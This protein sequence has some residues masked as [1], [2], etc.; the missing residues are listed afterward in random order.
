[1]PPN[2]DLVASRRVIEPDQFCR[3]NS[4]G[5]CSM[6]A[7]TISLLGL[8]WRRTM[9]KSVVLGVVFLSGSFT[10]VAQAGPALE[11]ASQP[12]TMAPAVA[13]NYGRLP[14][15]FEANQGQSD[16][17]VRFTSRGNGYSLFLTDS[18]AVLALSRKEGGKGGE[19]KAT[20]PKPGPG[21]TPAK[22]LL[23]TDVVR[24]QLAGANPGLRVAGEEPL[25]GTANYFIGNDPA[26]WHTSVPTY[27]KVKY[28]EVYPGVDLVYYG[29]QR[30][31]EYDFVVAPGV[32]P[33]EVKLHFVGAKLSLN[34]DGDL[35][36]AGKNGE[37]A[38]HKPVVYQV[39]S[40]QVKSGQQTSESP[41]DR[42][43]VDGSFTLLAGN[44]VRFRLGSYDK[45]RAVVIDP[46]LAYSTYLGGSGAQFGGDSGGGI[47][48][49]ASGNAYVTGTAYSTDFPVTKGA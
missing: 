1:M 19:Q 12:S 10:V 36:V 42:E 2:Q 24:M 16:P 21:K 46:A 14:L 13:A 23:K 11:A 31:L 6:R 18:E 45:S 3:L 9:L 17:R 22:V 26:K 33:K 30:Q 35:M 7:S 29:N 44:T 43:R 37:I 34:A 39:K 28:A 48:V 38:F 5:T 40:G 32:D 47:A 4:D 25:P 20:L 8:Y 27:A 15:S 41:S 49:D